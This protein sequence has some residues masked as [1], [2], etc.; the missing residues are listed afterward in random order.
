M[1]NPLSV[2]VRMLN[3]PTVGVLIVTPPIEGVPPAEDLSYFPLYIRL[4]MRTRPPTLK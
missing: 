2:G 3:L 1:L 4:E